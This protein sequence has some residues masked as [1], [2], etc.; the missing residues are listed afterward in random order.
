MKNST[1]YIGG[2]IRPHLILSLLPIIDGFCKKQNIQTIIFE[3]DVNT[4]LKSNI[5]Y[6]N[7]KSKYI[8]KNLEQLGLNKIYSIFFFLFLFIKFFF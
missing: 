4:F 1:I 2:G 7:L 5:L 8:I 3:R 6:K